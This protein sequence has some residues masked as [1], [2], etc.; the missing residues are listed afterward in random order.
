MSDFTIECSECDTTTHMPTS[1][2]CSTQG[3]AFDANRRAVYHVLETGGGYEALSSICSVV[4]M[5]F[6]SKQAYYK[7]VD[8]ILEA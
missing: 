8:G 3:R 5:P 1:S 2:T 7:Q 4:N 6:L